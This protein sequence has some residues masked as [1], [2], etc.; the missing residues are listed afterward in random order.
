MS[1]KRTHPV[2][3]KPSAWPTFFLLSVSTA[4]YGC[5]GTSPSAVRIDTIEVEGDSRAASFDL[6]V[7][8][9]GFIRAVQYDLGDKEGTLLADDL[10]VEIRGNRQDVTFRPEFTVLSPTT[11]RVR[12]RNGPLPPQVYVLALFLGDDEQA[13]ET[14][15]EIDGEERDGGVPRDAGEDP[16]DGGDDRDGG[17][18]R[19]AGFRD[20]GPPDSGLGDFE[21]AFAY[22][23]LVDVSNGGVI[24]AGVTVRIPVAHAT[25]VAAGKSADTALDVAVYQGKD[26][27]AHAFDDR[28]GV[29]TDELALLVRLL[30]DVPATG[31]PDG[32]PLALYY[33]DPT[34][35]NAPTDAVFEFVERFDAPVSPVNRGNDNA[36]SL[37]AWSHCGFQRPTVGAATPNGA[38]CVFDTESDV[39]SRYTMASPRIRTIPLD[40]PPGVV[41]ETSFYLTGAFRDG[42]A[43]LLYLSMGPDNDDFAGTSAIAEPP[44]TVLDF[45]LNNTL[46]FRETTNDLRTE[47][48]WMLP[49]DPMMTVW[50]QR[51]RVRF[52]PRVDQPSLHFRYISNNSATYGDSGVGLDDWWVR[53]AAD[54]APTVT[55]GPE[56]PRNP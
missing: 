13:R 41:Y 51:A 4:F 55:L 20:A 6:M 40:G 27:L 23:R 25:L 28:L 2:R 11:M 50:W 17:V 49:Q 26:L 42:T 39:P 15:F 21:G 36:W 22:R 3:S 1:H 37:N 19:D 33:G 8:G 14:L 32:D 29:A 53:A 7:S 56:E 31:A 16:I 46:T 12:V 48:G 35:T 10:A 9:G 43:D 38:Y 54:P 44:D 5:P 30:R 47:A 34:A 45:P 52:S 18:P 24:P